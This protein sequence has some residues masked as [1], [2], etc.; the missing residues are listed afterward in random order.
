M[1]WGLAGGALVSLPLLASVGVAVMRRYAQP[2][3]LR[4]LWLPLGLAAGSLVLYAG[5]TLMA[6]A[7]GQNVLMWN[8]MMAGM[9]L[10]ALSAA[11]VIW[12]RTQNL[13]G[14]TRLAVTALVALASVCMVG[15]ALLAAWG[16]LAPVC[17]ITAAFFV[18]PR[19]DRRLF[20]ARTTALGR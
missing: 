7:T 1:Q 3:P 20:N 2:R 19:L 5:G 12:L 15:V 8:S 11:C 10:L 14:A 4:Q 16:F 13:T 6:A 18:Y 9:V 17:S